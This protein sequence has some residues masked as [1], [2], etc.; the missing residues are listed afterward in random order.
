MRVSSKGY[1]DGDPIAADSQRASQEVV[2]KTSMNIAAALA[3]AIVCGSSPVLAATHSDYTKS[4]PLQTLKTFEFKQQ[5]RISRDPLANNELWANDV[6]EAVRNDLAG[7][8]IEQATNGKPDFYVAFYVGLQDR[9][10]V[11]YVPY[12]LPVFHRGFR[13]GW[14]GWP[15]GYDVWAVPYTQSTVIVDIIDAHTNQLV[16]RGYDTDTLNAKNP[17]KTLSKAVDNVL[18]RF[19]HDARKANA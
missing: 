18:S 2:M 6:R 14:W 13:T 19:Y 5:H 12:G 3:A 15:R 10:D 11:N 16:W 8:G 17:D 4:Y 1:R 9:Y 7:H